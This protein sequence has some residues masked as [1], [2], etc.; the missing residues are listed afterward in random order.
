[1]T[2]SQPV[3]ERF[4]NLV[5]GRN[6]TAAE[7]FESFDPFLGR[8]RSQTRSLFADMRCSRR[9]KRDCVVIANIGG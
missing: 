2:R 9:A 3:L 8:P 4:S 7:S 1:M 6:E 5:N